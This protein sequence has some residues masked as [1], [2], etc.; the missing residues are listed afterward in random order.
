MRLMHCECFGA[1]PVTDVCDLYGVRYFPA[2][3]RGSCACGE[4]R[5]HAHVLICGGE[6]I[7]HARWEPWATWWTKRNGGWRIGRPRLQRDVAGYCIKYMMKGE[8]FGF[9]LC[10]TWADERDRR[11]RAETPLFEQRKR[12]QEILQSAELP[13]AAFRG[14][15]LRRLPTVQSP[16]ARAAS[17]HVLGGPDVCPRCG[18][19]SLCRCQSGERDSARFNGPE[20]DA[21]NTRKQSAGA[22]A[23]SATMEFAG[24]TRLQQEL[25][26]PLLRGGAAPKTVL[27]VSLSRREGRHARYGSLS[28]H[29]RK[30][31]VVCSPAAI[32]P[33]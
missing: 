6:R 33:R 27:A 8:D 22:P 17:R 2:V 32:A 24:A 18:W 29:Y 14:E 19:M 13:T 4:K 5:L 20:L 26:S 21:A 1:C 7:A 28:C 12:G 30:H 25:F 10:S 11:Q 15:H 31:A 23:D 9:E 16:S 3:E